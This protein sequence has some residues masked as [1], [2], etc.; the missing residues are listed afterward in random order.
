MPEDTI[1]RI[2]S[3][4]SLQEISSLRGVSRHWRAAIDHSVDTLRVVS[5]SSIPMELFIKFTHLQRLTVDHMDEMHFCDMRQLNRLSS[6]R[7]LSIQGMKISNESLTAI[8][9]CTSLV[10]LTAADIT[11]TKN[12]S[13]ALGAFSQ[14]TQ[15]TQ[16]CLK[17]VDVEK[18]ECGGDYCVESVSKIPSLKHLELRFDMSEDV[19]DC[20]LS[21]TGLETL[22]LSSITLQIPNLYFLKDMARLRRLSLPWTHFS[23]Y[24]AEQIDLLANLTFLDLGATDATD[25][26]V[27]D[28]SRLTNLRHLCLKDNC[29][30]DTTAEYLSTLSKLESLDISHSAGL[31]DVCTLDHVSALVSLKSLNVNGTHIGD[32]DLENLFPL[33]SLERLDIGLTCVTESAINSLTSLANLKEINTE[34]VRNHFDHY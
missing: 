14:L 31:S 22:C 15:L 2:I 33:T 6:L 3:F 8:G 9:S 32:S 21:L 10:E 28:F 30:S 17:Y 27:Q 23:I 26:S 7:Y 24:D 29:I 18:V 16:L 11:L 5:L 20:L 34:I 1:G 13:E 19:L 25:E 12:C 4:M